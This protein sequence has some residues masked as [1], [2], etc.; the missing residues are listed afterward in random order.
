MGPCQ[1]TAQRALA[2]PAEAHALAPP[3]PL[4][5][6]SLAVTTGDITLVVE[7]DRVEDL[8]PRVVKCAAVAKGMPIPEP[9]HF[10]SLGVE[11]EL[12]DSRATLSLDVTIPDSETLQRNTEYDVYCYVRAWSALGSY[13]TQEVF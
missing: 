4:S 7:V 9:A 12:Q 3:V 10:S 11:G 5:E 8:E 2:P 13:S 6:A 1:A